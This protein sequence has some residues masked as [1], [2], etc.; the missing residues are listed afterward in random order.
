M[1]RVSAWI[2]RKPPEIAAPGVF[3]CLS[4]RGTALP[5]AGYQLF[6]SVQP[7]ANVVGNYACHDGDEE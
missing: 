1:R 5:Q 2:Q 7:F 6:I 4:M 3:F